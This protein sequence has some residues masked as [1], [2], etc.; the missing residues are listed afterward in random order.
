MPL[1]NGLVSLS[2]M[3]LKRLF[4]SHTN[5]IL[6]SS[7]ILSILL[8]TSILNAQTPPDLSGKWAF[9]KSKSNPG[10]GGSFLEGEEILDITQTANSITLNRTT[11][12]AGSDDI[13]SSDKYTLDGKESVKKDESCTTKTIAK[14]SDEKQILRITTIMT[15][16][17]VDYR[18]DDAYS[19]TDNGKTLTINSTSKNPTGGRKTISVYLKK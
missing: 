1:S 18:T 5:F 17:G 10:E 3:T 2:S 6:K 7:S 12:R 13:I 9:D 8:F 15:F 4:S 19:L 16:D 11:K 14:W